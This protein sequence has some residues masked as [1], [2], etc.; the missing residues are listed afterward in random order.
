MNAP[1]SR[2]SA[3]SPALTDDRVREVCI[4]G[5]IRSL[6][7]AVGEQG[8]PSVASCRE[9]Y[10]LGRTGWDGGQQFSFQACLEVSQ[11]RLFRP[12]RY[13]NQDAFQL[14]AQSVRDHAIFRLNPEGYNRT[15]AEPGQA[16]RVLCGLTFAPSV[17]RD[18]SLPGQT[19][20][21]HA[22][23]MLRCGDSSA[24][25]CSGLTGS[26]R[27]VQIVSFAGSSFTAG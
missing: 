14:L 10:W 8:T 27:C 17:D 13:P 2:V 7:V 3:L 18:A 19:R 16:D 11:I 12:D 25:L 1:Q 6:M 23:D 9:A 15:C 4:L 21:A 24:R 20:P 5:A 26:D 22:L